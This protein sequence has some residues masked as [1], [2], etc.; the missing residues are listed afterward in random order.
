MKSVLL[1]S[2]LFLLA[3]FSFAEE[4][5]NY[6]ITSDSQVNTLE[7]DLEAIGNVVIKSNSGNFEAYSDKLSFDKDDK[8]LKLIGNVYVKN[9]ESQGISIEE[10]SGEELTI[11]I[12][13]GLFEFKSQNKNRVKTKIKF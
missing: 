8:F 1:A 13:K 4:L 2:F 6:I 12:D 7:G 3:E 9:L 11:F 5:T 10:T